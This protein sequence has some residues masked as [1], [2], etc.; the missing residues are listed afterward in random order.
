MFKTLFW[1]ALAYPATALSL[2]VYT[3]DSLA[4]KDG[5]ADLLKKSFENS[6]KEKL[7]FIPFGSTGEALNQIA[8]EGSH[9]QADVLLG[10]DNTLLARAKTI[11]LFEKIPDDL[12]QNIPP[13]LKPAGERRFIPFDLGYLAFVYDRTRSGELAAMSLN[14][15]ATNK[16]YR[17]KLVIE[18]PR[19][20]SIGLSFLAFTRA[21]CTDEAQWKAL[22]KNLSQQL[23]T[24]TPGW[25]GAYGMFLK[26]EAEFVLSYTSSPAYHVEKEANNSYRALSFKEGHFRQ[27]EFVAIV[28][29]K[30]ERKGAIHF[31]RILLS[32]QIQELIPKTQWMFP[33]LNS[34]KLPESFLKIPPVHKTIDLNPEEV[35]RS[36]KKW[37]QQWVTFM[38]S[39][40]R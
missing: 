17:K 34:T 20:S 6:Q 23:I 13:D 1:I 27:V 7:T 26:K 35:D 29:T 18:D 10:L 21:L 3:Y 5:L 22:W 14:E 31:L 39:S 15:F 12:F 33:V 36:K 9:T 19:T 32:P 11:D 38:S 40:G 8:I 28:R 4:S 24:I 25:S 2:T 37:I 16:A 30:R